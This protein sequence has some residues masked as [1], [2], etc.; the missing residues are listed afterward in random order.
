MT[1]YKELY[2]HLFNALTDALEE[3]VCGNSSAAI[4]RLLQAQQEAEEQ[5]IADTF[6][7]K[8]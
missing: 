1:S 5:Y 3:L 8:S 7:D 6:Q 4:Q 2:F